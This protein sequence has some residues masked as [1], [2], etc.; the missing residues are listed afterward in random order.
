MYAANT[1]NRVIV[2]F[3][4]DH[5]A[6]PNAKDEQDNSVLSAAKESKNEEVIKLIEGL[7]KN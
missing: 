5:G 1:G 4:I 6:D 3:L 7:Q 2:S